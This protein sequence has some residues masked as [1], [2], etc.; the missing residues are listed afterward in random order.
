MKGLNVAEVLRYAVGR[1]NTL[2]KMK[3][4]NVAE[5][6]RYAVGRSNTLW[7]MKGLVFYNHVI[8]MEE[9]SLPT[10]S[11]THLLH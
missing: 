6:L 5:V 7:E 10:T 11:N 4:L 2:W 3:G 9:T 1:S 8:N